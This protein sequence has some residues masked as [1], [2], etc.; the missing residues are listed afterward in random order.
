MIFTKIIRHTRC[1][2]MTGVQTCALP[3]SAIAEE[4]SKSTGIAFEPASNKFEALASNDGLAFF[5]G[6]LNTLGVALTKIANDIRL[7]GSGQRA[8]LGE[9]DLPADEPGSSIMPGDRT[10]VV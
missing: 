4:L 7:L 3:I 10:S 2:L 5:S 9:L 1:A 8:G 6:A